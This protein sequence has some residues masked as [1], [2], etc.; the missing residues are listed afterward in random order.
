MFTYSSQKHFKMTIKITKQSLRNNTDHEVIIMFK[1]FFVYKKDCRIINH[2]DD[3][4]II[5][6][7]KSSSY[8][9]F[10]YIYLVSCIDFKWC[11]SAFYL[12]VNDLFETEVNKTV[13]L[14]V[15]VNVD[16]LLFLKTETN[17][18][19][20]S[21]RKGSLQVNTNLSNCWLASYHRSK[22]LLPLYIVLFLNWLT[23]VSLTLITKVLM[24][25]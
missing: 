18:H 19:L 24:I 16:I 3:L 5:S 25:L 21:S 15:V 17:A 4:R 13:V 22:C 1:P 14:V 9:Q 10:V 7:V 2:R 23:R 6:K 12:F 8:G 20:I 11:K